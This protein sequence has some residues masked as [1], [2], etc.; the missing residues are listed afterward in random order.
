MF[1]CQ[2]DAGEC[3]FFCFSTTRETFFYFGISVDCIYY[4]FSC[5]NEKIGVKHILLY[6]VGNLPY[7]SL[8]NAV[9]PE[10]G[11]SAHLSCKEKKFSVFWDFGFFLLFFKS[12]AGFLLL[13]RCFSAPA[14]L[15]L[16]WMRNNDT[17]VTGI[18][19][20]KGRGESR[21]MPSIAEQGYE[22]CWSVQIRLLW[23]ALMA[24][25]SLASHFMSCNARWL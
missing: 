2:Q 16:V 5:T 24:V 10:G 6:V 18:M 8:C 4:D 15:G 1:Q 3:R 21:P 19:W 13:R 11:F 20:V 7:P 12:V 22:C 17:R 14:L 25:G 9:Y 23:F